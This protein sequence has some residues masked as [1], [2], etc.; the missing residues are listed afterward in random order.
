MNRDFTKAG[1]PLADLEIAWQD[2]LADAEA[3]FAAGR[4]AGAMA[5]ALYALEIRLK[6]LICK[7]LE[8][9]SLPLAFEVHHLDGLLLLAGLSVRI[10]RKGAARV[11]QNWDKI[12]DVSG[13]LNDLRYKPASNWTHQD[14]A[15]LLSQLSDPPHGV[16]L[17]LGKQR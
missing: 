8:V 9:E 3:S 16:L 4:D 12:T 1:S 13:D 7:R 2:R 17:W 11:K 10:Q 14:A 15:A 5:A 6:V